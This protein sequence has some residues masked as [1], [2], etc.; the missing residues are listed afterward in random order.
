M[1]FLLVAFVIIAVILGFLVPVQAGANATLAQYYGHPLYAAL[2]NTLVASALLFISICL[3]RAPLPAIGSLSSA[4]WWSWCG[5]FIGASLV[6]SAILIA[7]RVGAASYVSA[8]IVGT[9]VASLIVDHFG[10][11]GFKEYP[12]DGW[13][14]FG[15]FLV[16]IGMLIIQNR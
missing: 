10:A 16:V 6:L 12:A 2:T 4:P 1:S 3:L 9:M 15:A 11:V 13:R 5:G 8:M 14:I 7:P